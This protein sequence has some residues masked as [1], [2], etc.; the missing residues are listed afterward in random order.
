MGCS[1]KDIEG[2]E[3]IMA[4]H[5][6]SFGHGYSKAGAYDSGCTHG[7]FSEQ[8]MVR[9]LKPHLKKWAEKPASG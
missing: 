3:I 1:N 8:E 6:I 9:R 4:K 7:G 2:G 5:L